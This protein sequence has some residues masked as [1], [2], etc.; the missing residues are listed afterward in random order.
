MPPSTAGPVTSPASRGLPSRYI[1]TNAWLTREDF[2]EH[3]AGKHSESG[4]TPPH[5]VYNRR[6]LRGRFADACFSGQTPAGLRL[7]AGRPL[8]FDESADN[9]LRVFGNLPLRAIRQVRRA[10]GGWRGSMPQS[11]DG[12]E[13]SIKERRRASREPWARPRGSLRHLKLVR[14]TP[15]PGIERLEELPGLDHGVLGAVV[16]QQLLVLAEPLLNVPIERE[17]DIVLSHQARAYCRL[18]LTHLEEK[19]VESI[20]DESLCLRAFRPVRA[21]GRFDCHRNI[22]REECGLSHRRD[23]VGA[24]FPPSPASSSPANLHRPSCR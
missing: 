3:G 20:C 13:G 21:Q 6:N 2:E 17:R 14:S 4:V 19:A 8:A 9:T 1:T 23:L 22:T 5:T 16:K 7:R 12:T 15:P 10:G 11:A 24:A 18:Q